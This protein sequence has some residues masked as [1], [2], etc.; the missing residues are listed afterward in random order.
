MNDKDK[1]AFNKWVKGSFTINPDDYSN[2][3]SRDAWEYSMNRE[4]IRSKV[5]L[6]FIKKLSKDSSYDNYSEEACQ[7][8]KEYRKSL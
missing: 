1:E 2:L 8:L 4:R 6:D 7:V 3:L 5:L